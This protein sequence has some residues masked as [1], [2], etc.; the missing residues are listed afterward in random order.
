[1][2]LGF[3][4]VYHLTDA[5]FLISED[6]F[7]FFDPHQR[8]YI[9]KV[10]RGYKLN[11]VDQSLQQ[12]YPN[13]FDPFPITSN[14]YDGTVFRYPLRTEDDAKESEISKKVYKPEEILEMFQRFYEIDNINCLIFLK[15]LKEIS[16]YQ[17]KEGNK[18][19]ELLYKIEITNNDEIKEKRKR[20][21]KDIPTIMESLREGIFNTKDVQMIYKANFKIESF[22]DSKINKSS[23]SE[24]L[25]INYL[26]DIEKTNEYFCKEF[27]K[28]IYDY[29]FVPN[30]ALAARIDK[31]SENKG[32]LFC[33]LPIPGTIQEL[34]I[35]VNGYFAVSKNRRSIEAFADKD[36][37]IIY[38]YINMIYINYT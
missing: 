28:N 18:E 38:I 37:V 15:S 10:Y 16:F 3:N 33:F 17:I 34:A 23:S 31:A 35:F 12:R 25:I 7:I 19:K 9:D 14:R 24:W 8:G 36:L 13:Q 26:G 11:F 6:K 20:I 1:M 30:V 4:S 29:K 5:P 21:A 22:V 32:R 27:K 2:G